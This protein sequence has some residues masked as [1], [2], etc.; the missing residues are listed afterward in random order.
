MCDCCI[1]ARHCGDLPLRV[2]SITSFIQHNIVVDHCDSVAITHNLVRVSWLQ[3]HP[4][5]SFLHHSTICCATVNEPDSEA[6]FMPVSRIAGQCAFTKTN[7]D[8]DYGKDSV[9]VCMPVIKFHS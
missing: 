6:C 3:D 8:F 2:G 1:L 5:R 4:R 7:Y 9:V